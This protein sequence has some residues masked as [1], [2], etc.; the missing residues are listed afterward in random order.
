MEFWSGG[1][2]ESRLLSLLL[3]LFPNSVWEHACTR[4]L[5]RFVPVPL[6]L[7]FPNSV[8]EHTCTRNSVSLRRSF[9]DSAI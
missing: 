1:V 2:D 7:L 9:L 8:W 3:L 6:Y 5:F 4:T